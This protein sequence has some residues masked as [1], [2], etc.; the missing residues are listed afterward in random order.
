APKPW[1]P[2]LPSV[3][4]GR[5]RLPAVVGCGPA[6][7]AAG[8]PA[9]PAALPCCAGGCAQA[10]AAR[11]SPASDAAPPAP[12]SPHL[13]PPSLERRWS[14][15]PRHGEV[16]RRAVLLCSC[17]PRARRSRDSRRAV[18]PSSARRHPS[19]LLQPLL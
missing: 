12:A 8:H 19:L 6:V 16:P 7:A 17:P 1:P 3:G 13:R 10:V 18:A 14:A 5:P 2:H 4:R 9:S 11:A 15:R